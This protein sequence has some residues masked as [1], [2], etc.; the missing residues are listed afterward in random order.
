MVLVDPNVI[1]DVLT[2]DPTW[3]CCFGL[4]RRRRCLDERSGFCGDGVGDMLDRHSD[5]RF[6]SKTGYSEGHAMRRHRVDV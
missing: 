3:R 5:A 2:E 6:E 1:I 4:E